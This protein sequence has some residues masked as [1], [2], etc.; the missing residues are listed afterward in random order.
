[1][2]VSV[3]N[4]KGF[5]LVEL[6]VVVA[7]IGI[8]A[9][10]A[11]PNFQRFT[12]K[13][14]QAEAKASLSALYSTERAFNSEWQTFSSGFVTVGYKPTGNLRY[15]HGF[16]AAF[17]PNAAAMPTGYTG[18]TDFVTFNSAAFCAVAANN[19]QIIVL[20]IAPQA[21]GVAAPCVPAGLCGAPAMAAATFTAQARA[22]LGNAVA[23]TDDVWG[24]NESKQFGNRDGLP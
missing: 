7:I 1:M 18:P 22:H 16:T 21:Y 24:I 2:K 12:A 15:T 13:S 19:C 9:A 5:S 3:S 23:A 17:P 11:I 4:N 10:I 8:L 20:P 6:M 14:K